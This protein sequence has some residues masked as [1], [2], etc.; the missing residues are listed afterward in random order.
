VAELASRILTL[1]SDRGDFLQVGFWTAL[2]RLAIS[3]FNRDIEQQRRSACTIAIGADPPDDPDAPPGTV[4]VPDPAL[5]VE[6][7]AACRDALGAIPEP[8]RTAFVLRRY[9]HWPIKNATPG[10]PSISRY[11]DRD[12]RTINNYLHRAEQA[13]AAWRGGPS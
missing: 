12:P 13:L 9:H 8:Y 1:T 7:L 11:F 10:A 5:S 2:E 6:D 3:T 4:D